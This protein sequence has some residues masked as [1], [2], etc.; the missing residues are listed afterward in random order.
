MTEQ[1]WGSKEVAEAWKA[2]AEERR[3]SMSVV[4]ER[5]VE[6][7]GVAAGMHVLDLG[8]GAAEVAL[9]VS[10]RVGAG[11]SVV[12]VDS[13]ASM[14]EAARQA[15]REAGASN[16][17][18][19]QSM[20]ASRLDLE[21]ASFDAVVAR[22]VLMFTDVPKALASVRR[23][24]RP[25]ARFGATVWGT[26]AANPYHRITIEAARSRS[27][28][29][30]PVPDVVRAFA[31]DHEGFWNKAL[32]DAGFADVGVYTLQIERPFASAEEALEAIRTSP[33]HREPIARL[34]EGE[35]EAAWQE[36]EAGCRAFGGV[37]P[38]QYRVLAGRAVG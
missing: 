3:R 14:I 4:T 20:D 18:V 38:S 2:R 29:G 7:A 16:V 24:L 30:E 8:T 28:W 35:R 36:I 33:I 37:F 5:M 31:Y 6:E 10:A 15:V 12:A 27:G 32:V 17:T 23:V 1:G 34:P 13:S 19:L 25:G 11:G 21:A 9:F 26:L 22:Q